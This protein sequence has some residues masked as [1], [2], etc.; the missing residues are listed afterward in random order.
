MSKETDAGFQPGAMEHA[1][2]SFETS[3]PAE[4]ITIDEQIKLADQLAAMREPMEDGRMVVSKAGRAFLAGAEA[5]LR[6]VSR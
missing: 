2:R 1:A 5:A 3:A 6:A 4:P